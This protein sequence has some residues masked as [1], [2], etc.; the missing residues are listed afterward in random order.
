MATI[1]NAVEIQGMRADVERLRGEA[2]EWKLKAQESLAAGENFDVA[3]DFSARSINA[4][5]EADKIAAKL[6]RATGEA[7][8]DMR[9]ELVT[10]LKAVVLGSLAISQDT[11]MD[12]V[13]QIWGEQASQKSKL[14]SIIL[15]FDYANPGIT[16]TISIVSGTAG[17][18]LSGGGKRG[19]PAGTSRTRT[20][21][22][23]GDAQLGPKNL[24]LKFGPEFGQ[25]K[26]YDQMV[27]AE[28]QELV[29]AIVAGKS[30]ETVQVTGTAA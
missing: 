15:G 23:V 16:P 24:V 29:A 28:R 4:T 30:L 21:F 5:N 9:A 19:A 10:E 14:H 26:P 1:S 13:R 7:Q 18:K 12:Y 22:I 20:R 3:M 25:M 8:I 6:E 27:P 2:A 11:I 17:P